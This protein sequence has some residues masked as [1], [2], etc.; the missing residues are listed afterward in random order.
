M[1]I[2]TVVILAGLLALPAAGAAA[3]QDPAPASATN[4]S[5]VQAFRRY[6]PRLSRRRTPAIWPRPRAGW[7]RPTPGS[8][9]T[10]A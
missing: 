1:H 4:E 5:D 9:T 10:P 6:G 2:A 3:H 8:P 7:P